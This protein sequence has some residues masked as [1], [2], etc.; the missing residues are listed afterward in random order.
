MAAG[1]YP[2]MSGLSEFIQIGIYFVS[3]FVL[4]NCVN[5]SQLRIPVAAIY[6]LLAV[7]SFSGLQPWIN[8]SG[9]NDLLGVAMALWDLVLAV[10]IL[11]VEEK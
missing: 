7:M 1:G 8:Y 6:G 3:A 2:L 9:S 4:F 10:V 11:T 5:Y